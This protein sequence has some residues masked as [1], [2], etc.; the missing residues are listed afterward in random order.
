MFSKFYMYMYKSVTH[1][2]THTHTQAYYLHWSLLHWSIHHTS[3]RYW[4][5]Y[6]WWCWHPDSANPLWPHWQRMGD[7][8]V[9]IGLQDGSVHHRRVGMDSSRMRGQGIHHHWIIIELGID[10]SWLGVVHHWYCG[11]SLGVCNWNIW[12]R[13]R[14]WLWAFLTLL[15]LLNGLYH[16][17]ILLGKRSINT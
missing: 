12:C 15:L 9:R 17:Y 5:R 6:H 7:K 1:T 11:W 10:Q 3:G 16:W 2:H 13:L 8:R 4:L 14:V